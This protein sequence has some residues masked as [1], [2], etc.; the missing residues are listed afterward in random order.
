VG[1]GDDQRAREGPEEPGNRREHDDEHA[2]PILPPLAGPLSPERNR[3]TE[4]QPTD[5]A[6]R[7]ARAGGYD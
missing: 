7:G 4:T 1:A 5:P 6:A 3:F 2:E